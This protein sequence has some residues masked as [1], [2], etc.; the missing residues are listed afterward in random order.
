MVDERCGGVIDLSTVM[1]RCRARLF[2]GGINSLRRSDA[3]KMLGDR[4]TGLVCEDYRLV[5]EAIDR[6]VS[7]LEVEKNNKTDKDLSK[8]L[9]SESDEAQPE[10]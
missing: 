2:G 1:N 8:I 5:R 4:L 9:L 3:A 10:C 7:L 6:G